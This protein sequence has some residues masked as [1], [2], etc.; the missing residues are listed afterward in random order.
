MEDGLYVLEENLND[1][2]FVDKAARIVRASMKGWQ[3]ARENPDEAADIV[4]E[5]DASGAQTEQ[6]QR[7]MMGRD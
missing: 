7:R 1:A 2:A 5:I 3:F 4:L 6:H